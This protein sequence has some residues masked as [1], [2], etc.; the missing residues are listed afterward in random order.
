MRSVP[1]VK[2]PAIVA[3]HVS[4]VYQVLSGPESLFVS[5]ARRLARRSQPSR[6][7]NA[8]NDVS[9]SVARGESLGVVGSNGA[10]KSTLLKIVAGITTP[11]S[12]A[13]RVRGRIAS[14]LALGCGFHPFL[15]GRENI[16]LQGT[17]L[18]MTNR[19]VRRN[20]DEIIA[21][22]GLEEMIDRP[23]WT[24]STGMIARLGFSI[25]VFVDFEVLLLDEAL[26]AGDAGFRERCAEA[27][28]GFRA[29]GATMLVVSHG[30]ENLRELCDRVAWIEHGAIRMIGAPREVLSRYEEAQ[31]GVKP[32]ATGNAAAS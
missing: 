29:R 31:R 28:R 12:G 19:D 18:G 4:K 3:E 20:I 10:G 21:Y 1:D 6:V 22:A 25:A 2:N 32:R 5:T 26:S 27:L 8:L 11:T 7:V 23:L 13:V 14:Q 30:S 16:F 15:S 9:L 24:Y 17:I